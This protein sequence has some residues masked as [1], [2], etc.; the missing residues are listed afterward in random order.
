MCANCEIVFL[1][2]GKWGLEGGYYTGIW[3]QGK[4]AYGIDAL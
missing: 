3:Q 4:D 1:K 2:P